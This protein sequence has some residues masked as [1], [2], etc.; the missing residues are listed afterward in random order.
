V[1]VW[2]AS[3]TG[4]LNAQVV[5]YTNPAA[6][7]LGSVNTLSSSYNFS[8]VKATRVNSGQFAVLTRQ[9]NYI[10]GASCTISGTTIS[11]NSSNYTGWQIGYVDGQNV[12]DANFND[13]VFAVAGSGGTTARAIIPARLYGHDSY[14]GRSNNGWIEVYYS[15]SS[16]SVPSTGAGL[17]F[18]FS[19]NSYST[20]TVQL[21]PL[22]TGAV[23]V[24]QQ[25]IPF[26]SYNQTS[27]TRYLSVAFTGVEG[28]ASRIDI[29]Y[30]ENSTYSI[31]AAGPCAPG[32]GP[33][34]W[35]CYQSNV[36][37]EGVRFNYVTISRSGSTLSLSAPVFDA[38]QPSSPS[39][40]GSLFNNHD[41]Y[42][43]HTFAYRR[44]G[45]AALR[46]DGAVINQLSPFNLP[47][48]ISNNRAWGFSR[49][50]AG[51][52]Q[53][54]SFVGA[55]GILSVGAWQ[56]GDVGKT[57][58][59]SG[60]TARIAS[61]SLGTA[62]LERVSGTILD[63]VNNAGTWSLS[64]LLFSQGQVAG[65]SMGPQALATGS[66]GQLNA[67]RWKSLNSISAVTT[68]SVWLALSFDNRRTWR[69]PSGGASRIVASD[70][71]V[72]HGGAD[73]VWYSRDGANGWTGP[74][75]DMLTALRDALGGSSANQAVP[76]VFGTSTALTQAGWTVG[77]NATLDFALVLASA[78][79]AIDSLT[80][81][82]S[83][84]ELFRHADGANIQIRNEDPEGVM[85]TRT[86]G[87]GASL[88]IYVQY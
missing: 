26:S 17:N 74:K 24:V 65:N 68:S 33:E 78:S 83:A 58:Y 5:N 82:Y 19:A 16:I 12:Y 11:N 60:G 4:Y 63:T 2:T 73:G 80:V 55:Q 84:Y 23:M 14:Y 45:G 52:M 54:Q 43:G 34:A 56:A 87:S 62:T 49:P 32:S 79:A 18:W 66:A 27:G 81:N 36:S 7:T 8:V 59:L 61:V 31:Q 42:P 37:G 64:P 30:N 51:S 38:T 85:V 15:Q 21:Y 20:P 77:W 46:L 70:R 86:A 39:W 29:T 50:D 40:S 75:A 35:L 88:R 6:P 72:D 3:S 1:I 44:G 69:I 13:A 28:T 9:G 57:L 76:S 48:F 67:R 25:A 22:H 53:P 47:E 71:A 41:G 10:G